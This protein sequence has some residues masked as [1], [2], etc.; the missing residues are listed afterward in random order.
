MKRLRFFRAFTLKLKSRL[1]EAEKN[2][3]PLQ[4]GRARVALFGWLAP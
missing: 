2:L 4:K 1:K 3:G